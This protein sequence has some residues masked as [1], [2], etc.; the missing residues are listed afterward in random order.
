MTQLYLGIK[1]V[2]IT[3]SLPNRGKRKHLQWLW[4]ASKLRTLSKDPLSEEQL[5][6]FPN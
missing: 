1:N 3:I 2:I 4:Q 5:A 6:M